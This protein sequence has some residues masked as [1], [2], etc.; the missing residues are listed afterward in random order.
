LKNNLKMRGT[1]SLLLWLVVCR[2]ATAAF[3]FEDARAAAKA[4][5]AQP[6]QP[7][8]RPVPGS[9]LT[10]DYERHRAIQFD[11]RKALWLGEGL[12]FALEFFLPGYLHK[13]VVML[14]EINDQ[15][16]RDIAFDPALFDN[17]GHNLALPADA[18]YAGFRIVRPGGDFGEVASFLDATYFRM[19]GRG[20][21]YGTSARGLGLNTVSSE[22][23]EFP[24]FREFWIQRPGRNDREITVYAVADSPSLAA[25][26]RFIIRPGKTTVAEVKAALFPRREVKG[27]EVAPLTSMFLFDENSHPPFHDFRPVVHDADGLLIHNGH[28]EWIWRPLETGKMTRVDAFQ[29]EQPRGFGLIERDRDFEHYQDL[30][31]AFQLRPNVWVKPAG[32]WGKGSVEL[33]QLASDQEPADNIV[34]FWAPAAPPTA[35][36][37][38][39]IEYELEWATTEPSPAELGQVVATRI[40]R[41]FAKPLNLRFV[42][43]FGG[44]AVEKLGPSE[45]PAATVG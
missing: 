38:M 39:E 16:V 4:L 33:V 29:D 9:L 35:G 25:A 31:A 20:Q 17:P 21:N 44:A 5:S 43:E 24:A 37:S 22:P 26:Y 36:Q 8:N 34:A 3:N 18:G 45:M 6:F 2:P 27:L 11:G 28:D 12:P 41:T 40:G 23:E 30:N 10:L 15:S 14:H 7:P 42:V 32:N 19:I 13:Q 1:L